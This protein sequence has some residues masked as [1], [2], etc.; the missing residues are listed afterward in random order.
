[1]FTVPA[2]FKKKTST[3]GSQV[4]HNYVSHIWIVLWVHGSNESTGV[5]HFQP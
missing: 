4:G 5:T 3:C 1:M 2:P